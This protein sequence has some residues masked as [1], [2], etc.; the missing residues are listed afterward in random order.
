MG[1]LIVTCTSRHSR[2]W[3]AGYLI[4][5]GMPLDEALKKVNMVVE[6]VTAAKAAHHLSQKY[7]VNMPIVEQ[8]YEVLFYGKSPVEAVG[9]LMARSRKNEIEDIGW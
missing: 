7:G 4:G 8:A 2:N 6:G 5:Q 1:D 9:A 3:K